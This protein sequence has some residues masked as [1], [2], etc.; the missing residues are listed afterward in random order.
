MDALGRVDGEAFGHEPLS[1]S[2]HQIAESVSALAFGDGRHRFIHQGFELGDRG[3]RTQSRCATGPSQRR[4]L[5][6]RLASF[7][8]TQGIQQVIGDLIRLA[9]L[10]A[11][12][13]PGA[14]IGASGDSAGHR[15]A[16]KQSAGLGPVIGA[17]LNRGLAFPGL[18]SGNA[19][20]RPHGARDRGHQGGQTPRCANAGLGDGFKRQHDQRVANQ[21]GQRLAIGGVHAGPATPKIGIVK[22]WQIVMH[23]RGAVQQLQRRS[24][25][26][27][28]S[29]VRIAASA[30]DR[31]TE[32]RPHPGAAGKHGVAQ[33]FSEFRRT[34]LTCRPLDCGVQLRFDARFCL[35]T[36][37]PWLASVQIACHIECHED[38][39]HQRLLSMTHEFVSSGVIVIG[40]GVGGLAAAIDLAAKGVPVTLIER[41]ETPGG[42]MRTLSVDGVAVA[43]GPTVLTLREAFEDLFEGAGAKLSD[44]V[45]LTRADRL[46]RHAWDDKTRLDLF[47]DAKRNEDEIGRFSGA[48]QTRQYRTFLKDS[49]RLH[50]AL[51]RSYLTAPRPSMP[52]LVGRILTENPLGL[53]A[54]RPFAS[55]WNALGDYFPDPRLRQL[56]ARYATYCGASP[57]EAPATLMLIPHIEQTGV[58]LID[59]GMARLAK[60]L[61]DLAISLGVSIR[62]GEGVDEI[63]TEGG[64]ACGVK[65]DSGD[66][67]SAAAVLA[68]ADPDAIRAGLLGQAA[69][70]APPQAAGPRALSALVW[71]ATGRA[72]GFELDHHNVFFS[73]DYAA[74]FNALF[75][76]SRIP[77][78]PTVY[79]CAQDRGADTAPNGA[80]R[81]LILINAPPDGD[82]RAYPPE[83]IETWLERTQDRLKACGLTLT[84]QAARATAPDGFAARFPGTGGALY[85]RA[86]HGWRAAFQRPGARTRLPGLYL[87]GG[88]THPGPGV[89]TA[90]LS[91]RTAARSILADFASTPRFRP[92]GIAGSTPIRSATTDGSASS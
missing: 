62:Y 87:A 50:E 4:V 67:L 14:G 60:A 91:G 47:A 9:D 15:S 68:N 55:L 8:A 43:A 77:D 3:F 58:W 7:S 13:S 5:A 83:E 30:G 40:A 82:A 52:G 56:Y 46:A 35:H 81:F 10:G 45:R 17:H 48:R 16:H 33:S 26:I 21:H 12:R 92:A 23:K 27:G 88:G 6:D 31:Q 70:T 38:W 19:A 37:L 78:D 59:G 66:W 86:L 74:E 42:K 76:G 20:R 11:Q 89:P 84:I 65:L 18:T 80:E 49:R 28:Q 25:R 22:G 24:G 29:R 73:R 69:Q 32:L 85:G 57:F 72:D 53:T 54:L 61:A 75:E 41:A 1:L 34:V 90:M 71:T 36:A 51:S 79:I 2:A 64:R 44:H 63:L 39:T